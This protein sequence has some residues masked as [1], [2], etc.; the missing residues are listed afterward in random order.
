MLGLEAAVA[1]AV[2][3]GT[4]VLVVD[5]GVYGDGLSKCT[6]GRPLRWA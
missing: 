4:M 2:K 1:N 3:P 5:N 6:A